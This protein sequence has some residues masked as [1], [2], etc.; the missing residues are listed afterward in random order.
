MEFE[1]MGVQMRIPQLFK[2]I[3]QTPPKFF[4]LVQC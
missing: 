2:V 3:M 4:R 1:D